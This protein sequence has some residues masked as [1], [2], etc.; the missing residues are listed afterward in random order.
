MRY[1]FLFSF[2]ISISAFADG[3]GI[4]SDS[5]IHGPNYGDQIQELKN[6]EAEFAGVGQYVEYG[7]TVEGRPLAMLRIGG[8]Q[9]DESTLGG[10]AVYIGGAT[11]GD[12]Y[13][14]IEDRLARIFLT[15]W[16]QGDRSTMPELQRFVAEGGVIYIA[17]IL[18][19]DGY[20]GRY[21]ENRNGVDLNRDFGLPPE[22][23]PGFTQP[24]TRSLVTTLQRDAAAHRLN[25]RVAVDYHCCIGALLYPWSYD[26][27]PEMPRE[28]E[29]AYQALG[30]AMLRPFKDVGRYRLGKTP[31]L[32]GYNAVG[33]S[34]DYYY[35]VHGTLAFTFEGVFRKEQANLAQHIAMWESV[36]RFLNAEKA[37]EAEWEWTYGATY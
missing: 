32:L 12:E 20:E 26:E 21:R 31:T 23:L 24:E 5:G 2:L 11:H 6:L 14:N 15:E 37:A 22:N 30:N 25:L 19:P 3:V 4:E 9:V 35:A 33:T 34:K 10:K 13:L 18:N 1:A 7:K 8:T 36:F 16:A 28:H 27:G 29:A 17:P